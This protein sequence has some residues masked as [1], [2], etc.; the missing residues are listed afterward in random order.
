MTAQYPDALVSCIMPTADRGSFVVQALAGFRAQTYPRKELIV[1][2]D[3]HEQIED[4]LKF[5]PDVRYFRLG[6][7]LS[8]GAKRNLA[9]REARGEFIA[10]WDDDDWY[11]P[12]RLDHQL[13]QLLASGADMNGLDDV[14][15]IDETRGRAWEYTFPRGQGA[16]VYGATMCYRRSVWQ[17]QPFLNLND[18][19]D[20]R[21]VRG[22]PA[23]RVAPLPEIGMF[24]GR[25]HG[26]NT[27]I[28]NF[29]D[30]RFREQPLQRVQNI[31]QEF[32]TSAKASEAATSLR[33]V[34]NSAAPQLS[35]APR[36]CVGVHVSSEP[37]RLVQTLVHLRSSSS[38]PSEILLLGDGVQPMT[39]EISSRF[40]PFSESSTPQRRGAAACFN[41]LLRASVADV[42]IL[43][44]NGALVGSG[45]LELILAALDSDPH[46]CLAGPTTN[47]AWSLQGAYRNRNATAANVGQLAAQARVEY[48]GAHRTLEPLYCLGDFCYVVR[49]EVADVIG[50][51]DER[52][53]TGPCWEMD[54]T[55]RAVRSGFRAVW[56]Q[57]AYVF[58]P[59]P[60][61]QRRSDERRHFEASK[62]RYQDKFCGKR[63]RGERTA[64]A[65]HCLG[66][67]C[68][69]FAPVGYI[70]PERADSLVAETAITALPLVSCIMPTRGRHDWVMQSIAYFQRQ[71]YPERELIIIDDGPSD[72]SMQLSCLPRIRYRHVDA[73]MSIGAKRNLACDLAS[74]SIIVHWDDDDWYG[75]SRLS[76]QIA[77]L[78]A[79]NAH[80]TALAQPCFFD[81]SRWVFWECTPALY[82]KLFVLGVHGGTL[83][84]SRWVYERLAKYPD[85]SLAED[86]IFLTHA[87]A[88]GARLEAMASADLFLYLRHADNAWSFACG[89]YIDPKGWQVVQEP[90][91]LE[92]DINFYASRSAARQPAASR[93]QEARRP[94]EI[95]HE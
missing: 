91:F 68:S 81:L 62:R 15:F 26:A 64:Y 14:L 71:D 73:R 78:R 90:A 20:T 1:I 77:P 23:S 2:D 60:T 25:I 80:I 24:V 76:A 30:A 8:I 9:C 58:R 94:A 4:L 79:G 10:H 17:R 95:M 55:I 7:K 72:R 56:A 92:G 18:G 29:R 40:G 66:E 51:A 21:F 75:P 84:Y 83:A 89:Q 70:R 49:R 85:I 45:W 57:G 50:T 16:W 61:A 5:D 28:K 38:L 69:A 93:P 32:A 87:C 59:P 33:A 19:E 13:R 31:M 39:P 37:Q 52:F 35:H 12:W 44:E 53:G 47:L 11:A 88:R 65:T 46:N 22:L 67:A 63:L 43:L 41:R 34:P 42:I 6:G 36:V 3:G 27:S 74:G 82:R 54:Y 48:G 86:A